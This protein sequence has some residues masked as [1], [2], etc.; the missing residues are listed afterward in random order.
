MF[1]RIKR[2]DRGLVISA[3]GHL[4]LLA[5]GLLYLN[6]SAHDA[7]PPEATLVELVRPQDIPHFSGAP[8]D[9][10]TSG[11]DTPSP[12]SQPAVRPQEAKPKPQP[13]E[14]QQPQKEPRDAEKTAPPQPKTPPL[15]QMEVGEATNAPL[16]QPPPEPQP[17]A[18]PPA[19]DA[20]ATAA[21]RAQQAMLGG[22]LGGGF[23]A[24]PVPS[25]V[26]GFDY[27][28]P[29]R[30]V[31]SSC[32]PGVPSVDP[33]ERIAVRIRVFLNRDGT[34][35]RAPLMREGNPSAKQVA[36]MQSFAAGLEKC[37]PYTMLPADKY[38]QWKEIDLV[39]YP[40]NSYGG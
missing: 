6:A 23:N 1:G 16:E 40:V 17:A 39:V 20:E 4:A 22:P 34:L 35:T 33:R 30:R 3:I 18:E 10:R 36:M 11:L 31:V 27:T 12:R 28:E 32:A 9:L 25:P 24:P 37:Q 7:P 19:P 21:Q 29:F 15:P 26:T 5:I 13:K 2:L 8:T 14:Q 38:E